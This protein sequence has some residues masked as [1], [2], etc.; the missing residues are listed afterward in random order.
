MLELHRRFAYPAA[1]LV[2]GFLAVPLFVTRGNYS[3]S[4]GGVIGLV[5]TLA[6]YGLMLRPLGIILY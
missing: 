6:Y 4:G 1:T 2:F 3:R 5:C